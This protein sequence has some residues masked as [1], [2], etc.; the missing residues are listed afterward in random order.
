MVT[1]KT[2]FK[3]DDEKP[4]TFYLK[5]SEFDKKKSIICLN[6]IIGCSS[7]PSPDIFDMPL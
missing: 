6:Y 5:A 7:E 4:L 3:S 2:L 1:N